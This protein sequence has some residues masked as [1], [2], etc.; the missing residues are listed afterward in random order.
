ML[1]QSQIPNQ[2]IQLQHNFQISKII[3]LARNLEKEE[4]KGEQKVKKIPCRNNSSVKTCIDKLSIESASSSTQNQE[5]RNS[6]SWYRKHDIKNCQEE[7][8]HN[9]NKKVIKSATC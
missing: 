9:E 2:Q 3:I 5:R 1:L 6:S 7:L 4:R 8:H